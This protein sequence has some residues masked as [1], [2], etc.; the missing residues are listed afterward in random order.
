MEV[1]QPVELEGP[2][3]AELSIPVEPEPDFV[4]PEV[5]PETEQPPLLNIPAVTTAAALQTLP[6]V[7][8]HIEAARE[9]LSQ[10]AG[11]GGGGG[12][13]TGTGV[14]TGDGPGLGPG[15]GGGVGGGVYRPGSGIENP[16]VLREVRPDYTP[17]AMRAKVQGTVQLEVV[18]LPNGSVGDVTVIKSLDRVFGLDDEARKAARQWRF[19]PGTRFGTPVAV[20]VV[21]ELFF[22]LR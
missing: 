14:G 3:E 6:G 11:S 1:P 2:D 22:S 8:D 12:T 9:S 4:E 18:V 5:E 20:A 13:G 7:M 15:E 21:L 10:G 19:A 16:E 17:E